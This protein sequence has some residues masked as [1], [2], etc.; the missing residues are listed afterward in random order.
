MSESTEK[1]RPYDN[2]PGDYL[3]KVYEL[4]DK[5]DAA[6][7]SNN[8]GQFSD[9]IKDLRQGESELPKVVAD[10]SAVRMLEGRKYALQNRIIE[11]LRKSA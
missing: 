4:V 10:R 8:E 1:I 3:P 9:L 2:N 11:R 7:S 6:I 5:V